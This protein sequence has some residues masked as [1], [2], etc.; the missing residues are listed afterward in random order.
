M[1]ESQVRTPP[2]NV[3][4]NYVNFKTG[5]VFLAT[6]LAR[7]E[8]AIISVALNPGAASTNLFRHTPMTKYLAWPLLHSARL[9]ALTEL[10]AGLS[11]DIT[12]EKNGC[13]VVPWGRIADSGGGLRKDLVDATKLVEDGGTGQAA[14]LWD[15]CTEM[16]K[17]FQ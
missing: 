8:P 16:T 3:T 7:R 12:S 17:E 13:Y 11:G 10:Y 1:V 15:W 6:E 4:R 14:K 5:N 2:A 9:A